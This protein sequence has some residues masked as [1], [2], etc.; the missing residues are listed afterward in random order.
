MCPIIALSVFSAFNSANAVVEI[1]FLSAHC[2]ELCLVFRNKEK[3]F[4]KLFRLDPLHAWLTVWACFPLWCPITWPS[5]LHRIYIVVTY[6]HLVLMIYLRNS[7]VIGPLLFYRHCILKCISIPIHHDTCLHKIL[8]LCVCKCTRCSVDTPAPPLGLVPSAQLQQANYS[9]Q[10]PLSPHSFLPSSPFV[11]L[12]A[13]AHAAQSQISYIQAQ[14]VELHM[15]PNEKRRDARVVDVLT[16]CFDG[17]GC[18]APVRNA[19][20]SIWKIDYI[21]KYRYL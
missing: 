16:V 18:L 13:A 12:P 14:W 7:L 21:I 15:R 11:P 9:R 17:D 20:I 10:S 6:H 5:W 8:S 1:R 3:K 2:W 19:D 4:S